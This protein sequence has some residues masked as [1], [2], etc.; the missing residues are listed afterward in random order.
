MLV[1]I[2]NTCGMECPHCLQNSLPEPMHMSMETVDKVIE[3]IKKTP[4]TTVLIS[5]GEPTMHPQFE[6]IV[7]RFIFA[8]FTNITIVSN[9]CWI[10]NKDKVKMMKKLLSH[11]NVSLQVTSTKEYY[12]NYKTICANRDKLLNL[13][14]FGEK[15]VS[16][17]QGKIYIHQLGRASE[18]FEAE[19]N[20][21][22]FTTSCM[23]MATTMYQLPFNE[24][25]LNMEYRSHFCTPLIDWRGGIHLSES[26]LCPKVDTIDTFDRF[27]E[28]LK[29]KPCGKCRDYQKLLDNN[30]YTYVKVKEMMGI[31]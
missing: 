20:S 11:K 31:Q 10:T 30:T 7:K 27:T 13:T 29:W 23:M 16:I 17:H 26:W 25:I 9:G 5:G 28:V 18:G 3:F 4:A 15:K 1:Q 2:T 19:A 8:K 6:A 12:K 21:H 24:A 14:P 22:I